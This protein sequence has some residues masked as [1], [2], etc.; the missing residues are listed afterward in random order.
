MN[1]ALKAESPTH[2]CFEQLETRFE[3][4]A[5]VRCTLITAPGPAPS[6]TMEDWKR[7]I[8][9]YP[10]NLDSNTTNTI[11]LHINVPTL[12]AENL[13]FQTWGSAR[14]LAANLHTIALPPSTFT[15]DNS[16]NILELGAGTGLAGLAA[17]ALWRT[18]AV[19]TDLP[20]FVPGLAENI[21]V[22]ADTLASRNARVQSGALDWNA[23][24]TL[25]IFST[26]AAAAEQST[27]T[28]YSSSSKARMIIAAD[29]LYSEEHPG[30]LARTIFEWLDPTPE[31]RVVLCYPLRVAYLDI[32]REL[33]AVLEEGGLESCGEGREEVKDEHWDDERWHEWGVFR[34][35]E[36]DAHG[37]A[38]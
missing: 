38:V 21:A 24:S 36:R 5:A 14:I 12:R 10:V 23:P 13:H 34:W 33:W 3:A 27:V 16:V 6:P 29:T 17:A 25:P 9:T 7:P 15:S 35:K 31:A 26:D 22:N 30:M 1:L 11:Q 28:L 37:E 19:L 20:P 32:I 8:N 4:T 2:Q 18:S